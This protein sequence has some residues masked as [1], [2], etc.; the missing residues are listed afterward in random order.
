MELA[1]LI[2]LTTMEEI[3]KN[4]DSLDPDLSATFIYNII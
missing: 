3:I 4:L 1:M 2:L